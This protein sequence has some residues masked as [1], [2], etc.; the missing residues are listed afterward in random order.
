MSSQPEASRGR[1]I[2]FE[3]GDGS[4]K[5]TQAQLLA[6]RIGAVL[7]REPG[8]TPIGEQI[9]SVVLDP[10][11]PELD[12]RTEA[13]LMA[14]SRAQH[15]A[16]LIEPALADGVSVVSDRFLASSL[17]YQGVARG[18]GVESVAMANALALDGLQPDL[19]VLLSVPADAARGRLAGELDRIE[20]ASLDAVVVQAY[21]EFAA[22]D[23]ERW[24]V[25]EAIGSIE[26][27]HDEVFAGVQKRLGL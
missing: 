1:F 4:G 21:E 8:G 18:L 20:R 15:V 24:L 12:A 19:T 23:P 25:V 16:E 2:V 7:T 27:I 26:D 11:L 5:S 3:G 22:G 10:D 13:L 14:A 6:K 17:A 9:R